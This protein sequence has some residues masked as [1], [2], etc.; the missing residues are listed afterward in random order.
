MKRPALIFSI[1]FV[2]MLSSTVII[3][4]A[5]SGICRSFQHDSGKEINVKAT[6]ADKPIADE[7]KQASVK[8]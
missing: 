4:T 2:A 8:L 1:L 6:S 7:F 3:S 5:V